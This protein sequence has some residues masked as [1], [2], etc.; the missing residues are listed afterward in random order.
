MG[1]ETFT[2]GD[3]PL[4]RFQNSNLQQML[5]IDHFKKHQ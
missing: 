5:V 2:F 1:Y 4:V 3:R